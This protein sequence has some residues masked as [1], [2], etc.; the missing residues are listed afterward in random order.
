[1]T[2]KQHRYIERLTQANEM[3]KKELAVSAEAM[4]TANEAMRKLSGTLNELTNER[5]FY[6]NKCTELEINHHISSFIREPNQG[7]P[8]VS[9]V[10]A[11][12]ELTLDAIEDLIEWFDEHWFPALMLS[13]LSST[14]TFILTYYSLQ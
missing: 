14:L 6:R 13:G 2:V 10:D 9:V 4:R 5:D 8:V 7:N 11:L 1:M 3:L 12:G